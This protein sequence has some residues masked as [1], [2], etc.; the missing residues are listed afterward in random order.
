MF[1]KRTYIGKGKVYVGP[2]DGSGP[3]EHV[4]NCLSL[5]I[6]IEESEITVPDMTEAGGGD[7]DS[8]TRIS[9]VNLSAQLS[10]LVVNNLKRGLRAASSA[11]TATPVA[12]ETHTA[13][14]GGLISL[15]KV[16]NPDATLTVTGADGTGVYTENTDYRRTLSGIEILDTGAIADGTSL[17]IDYT[18]LPST[19]IQALTE[20]AEKYKVVFEGLNE[21]D[22][23]KAVIVKLHRVGLKSLSTLPLIGDQFAQIPLNGDV[24][25]DTSI[26]TAGL[27]RFFTVNQVT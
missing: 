14:Q 21:A 3:L 7:Y 27:S 1:T 19:L 4:G 6:G 13:Y 22:S 5:E 9:A 20:V 26:T 12:N 10:D 25:K 8:L 15:A 24:L 23:G 16:P 17:E 11:I 2:Y 18:P